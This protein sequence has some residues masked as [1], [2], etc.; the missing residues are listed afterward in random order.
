MCRRTR[1]F[2]L[3]CYLLIRTGELVCSPFFVAINLKKPAFI[4]LFLRF[5]AIFSKKNAKK[6]VTETLFEGLY[7]IEMKW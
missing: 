6:S 3:F 2:A 5:F 4:T 7:I 1:A